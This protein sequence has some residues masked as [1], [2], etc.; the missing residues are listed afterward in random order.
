MV[1]VPRGYDNTY[2]P[3]A[4]PNTNIVTVD[5]AMARTK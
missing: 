1:Y 3:C 4:M 5:S 2:P